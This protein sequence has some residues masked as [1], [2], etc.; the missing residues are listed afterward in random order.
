MRGAVDC[1]Y[2]HRRAPGS[3]NTV[4]RTIVDGIE[5]NDSGFVLQI[6]SAIST[7]CFRQVM[8]KRVFNPTDLSPSGR[9][10]QSYVTFQQLPE[11]VSHPS[12]R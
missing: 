8:H 4:D 1:G 5:Q 11:V 7:Q 2:R 9:L 10:G 3:L 12:L 6:V